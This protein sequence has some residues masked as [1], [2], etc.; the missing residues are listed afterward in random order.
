MQRISQVKSNKRL[1][2][3]I[4]D[5]CKS[6][7]EG[8]IWVTG[9]STGFYDLDYMTQGFQKGDLI[10]LAGREWTGK[11]ALALSIAWYAAVKENKKVAYFSTDHSA[12]Q[13]MSRL[14]S[15]DS[16]INS[17]NLKTGRFR[18]DE[19]IKIK[20]SAKT[21]GK[22]QLYIDDTPGLSVEEIDKRCNKTKEALSLI[23]ID[24]LQLLRSTSKKSGIMAKQEMIKQIKDLAVRMECPVMLISELHN[25]KCIKD[26]K[27]P[28]IFE[29][30]SMN[31]VASY[32]DVIMFL[33]WDINRLMCETEKPGMVNLIIDKNRSGKKGTVKL[34]PKMGC[35]KF[36]NYR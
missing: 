24:N 32:S 1:I 25:L 19:A 2:N 17:V 7:R 20:S 36:M 12:K 28:D 6:L 9:L 34:T 10:L 11:T 15:I 4:F 31:G 13:I 18:K 3:E 16:G 29:L 22:S 14:L 26:N 27:R 23:I 33:H 8:R 30:D 5:D 35:S 21:V